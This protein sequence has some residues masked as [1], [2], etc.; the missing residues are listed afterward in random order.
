MLIIDRLAKV[1]NGS[2]FQSAVSIFVIGI[3]SNEDCGNRVASLDE[4]PIEFDPGHRRHMDVSDQAGCFNQ[5]RRYEEIGSRRESLDAVALG[6][7][8]SFHRLAKELIILDDRNYKCSLH[9]SSGSLHKTRHTSV[10]SNAIALAR[11]FP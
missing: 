4:L 9:T 6:S 7:H 8:Q 5:A 10:P 11:E 2:I 3:G 1:T